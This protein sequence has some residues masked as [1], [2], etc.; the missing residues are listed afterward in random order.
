MLDQLADADLDNLPMRSSPVPQSLRGAR[1]T[2]ICSVFILALVGATVVRFQ[3]SLSTTATGP[4]ASSGGT[5]DTTHSVQETST[6]GSELEVA[7]APA[8]EPGTSTIAVVGIGQPVADDG[9]QF[10]AT[11]S[12]GTASTLGAGPTCSETNKSQVL[13]LLKAEGPRTFSVRAL[14]DDCGV[15]VISVALEPRLKQKLLSMG[16]A[17]TIVTKTVVPG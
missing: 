7:A 8:A 17:V 3:H 13:D 15:E 11:S 4:T 12:P 9:F 16:F 2:L 10:P 5:S 1:L 6:G 14:P